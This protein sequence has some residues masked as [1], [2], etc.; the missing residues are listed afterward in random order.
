MTEVKRGAGYF[1]SGLPITRD[2]TLAYAL[3]LVVA[4]LMAGASI[5]GLL[6][7]T[8]IYPT[9]EL[10]RWLV[11]N[12]ALN[13]VA[14]LPLL[15]GSMGLA[16][17]GRLIGLLCWPGALFYVLYVYLAY[18]LSVPF[19]VLFL[20]YLLLV[21][22]SACTLIG[23]VAS[24]DGEAVRQRLSG[25]VPARVS[26]GILLGLAILII[27]RQTALITTAL[28]RQAQ[29][30]AG[31]LAV[32]IDDFAVACPALLVVGVQLWRRRALGYVGGGGLFLAYGVLAIGLIPGMISASP[33]DVGGIIVVLVM[34]AVCLAPFAF[35]VRGA[36]SYHGSS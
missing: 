24:V 22:L 23:L 17:R 20:P 32:W 28:I 29:V 7:P 12:D 25:S 9:D 16:R 26:G 27:A 21:S 18:T 30:G 34:A 6:H 5:V 2:L 36:T 3:S 15:L 14:G 4:L 10:R 19:G 1:R 31:E 35:F 13:L 11:T 33:I 8:V